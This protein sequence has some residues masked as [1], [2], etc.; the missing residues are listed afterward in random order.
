VTNEGFFSNPAQVLLRPR[1][2]RLRSCAP[3]SKPVRTFFVT[4]A[5]RGP[6]RSEMFVVIGADI[7]FL[8]PRTRRL[9]NRSSMRHD[10]MIS[11]DRDL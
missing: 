10:N 3:S 2:S 1:K 6:P 9:A 11:S 8:Q 4:F 5:R 7:L